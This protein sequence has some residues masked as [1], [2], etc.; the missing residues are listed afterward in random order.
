MLG[1]W[2]SHEAYQKSMIY[3][4]NRFFKHN[5]KS[6]EF[7]SQA[8]LKMYFLNLDT[9]YEDFAPMFSSIGRPSN[10]QPQLF[11][12]LLLMSHFKYASIDEWVSYASGNE[13]LRALVCVDSQFPGASIRIFSIEATQDSFSWRMVMLP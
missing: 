11:R 2:Q 12:S 10:L 4:V 9:V 6:I 5:P 3:S 13:I 7:Y 8:I 1:H